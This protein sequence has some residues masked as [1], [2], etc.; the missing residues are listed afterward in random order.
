MRSVAT[1]SGPLLPPL[2]ESGPLNVLLLPRLLLRLRLLLT[3]LTGWVC[4]LRCGLPPLLEQAVAK[5][6]E[7]GRAAAVLLLRLRL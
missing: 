2:N 3:A 4:R 5:A 6:R 1:S 7:S